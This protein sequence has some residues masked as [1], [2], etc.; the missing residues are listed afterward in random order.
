MSQTIY[1]E[2]RMLLLPAQDCSDSMHGSCLVFKPT[3][4]MSSCDQETCLKP[5]WIMRVFAVPAAA[6]THS[7]R[8]LCGGLLHTPRPSSQEQG[9]SSRAPQ[10]DCCTWHAPGSVCTEV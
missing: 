6:P 5:E 4:T 1:R 9:W 2:V 10:P 7:S 3:C 8:S